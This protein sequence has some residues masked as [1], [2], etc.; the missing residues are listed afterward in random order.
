[1]LRGYAILFAAMIILTEIEWR[2]F[3][4]LFGFLENWVARGLTY[5]F[6]GLI[7]WDQGSDYGTVFGA[8]N[9]TVAFMMIGAG[10]FYALLGMACMKTV[11]EAE[12]REEAADL[13]E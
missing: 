3:M 5:A 8:I 2:G 13:D 1:M 7:T 11:K 12:L 10:A 4:R 6:V 9:Q